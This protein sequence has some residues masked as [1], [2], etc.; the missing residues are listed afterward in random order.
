MKTPDDALL[1]NLGGHFRHVP[2]RQAGE[3]GKLLVLLDWKADV[4]GGFVKAHGAFRENGEEVPDMR[5]FCFHTSLLM[6]GTPMK[7][8]RELQKKILET[9]ADGYGKVLADNVERL[10]SLTDNKERLFAN[11]RY[12]DEH[13][14]INSGIGFNDGGMYFR[15][16]KAHITHRGL[17]FLSDDGGLSAVLGV[18]TVRLHADT[19]RDLVASRIL[20]M[21]LPDTEKNSLI[22]HL[23]NL[24]ASVLQ[25]LSI[26]LIEKGLD[27]LPTVLHELKKWL[28]P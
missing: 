12:L 20:A 4:D 26:R 18:V 9:L 7:L 15:L 19:V 25:V 28:V 14:L 16:K 21:P 3:H 8:D 27:Q 23:R 22:E 11:L 1:Q 6:K 5:Q 24:P 2:V 10:K 17:D 13:G